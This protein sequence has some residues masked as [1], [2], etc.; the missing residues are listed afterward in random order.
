MLTLEQLCP[1]AVAQ[2]GAGPKAAKRIA[3]VFLPS[4]AAVVYLPKLIPHISCWSLSTGLELSTSSTDIYGYFLLLSVF[5]V[6]I[7]QYILSSWNTNKFTFNNQQVRF[8]KNVAL[9][10]VIAVAA[11]KIAGY[12]KHIPSTPAII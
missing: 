7:L 3:V 8:N 2:V 4:K 9:I 1:A 11:P 12:I 5:F 6:S 10:A